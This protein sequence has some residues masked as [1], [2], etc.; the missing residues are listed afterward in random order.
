MIHENMETN[1]M[2]PTVSLTS[3]LDTFCIMVPREGTQA[4]RGSLTKIWQRSEFREAKEAVICGTVNIEE[5][6][7]Q[8]EITQDICIRVST[9]TKDT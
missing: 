8:R 4:Q 5:R 6:E 1:E 3:C 2:H 9:N 7:L